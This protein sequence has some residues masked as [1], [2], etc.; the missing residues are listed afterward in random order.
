MAAQPGCGKIALGPVSNISLHV[1]VGS[2]ATFSASR[3]Q[4]RLFPD[5]DRDSDPLAGR[6][7]PNQNS[8]IRSPYR[9]VRG[10]LMALLVQWPWLLLN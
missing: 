9:R 3:S 8:A 4:V 10:S 6:Y 7:A 1:R 5:T 2:E